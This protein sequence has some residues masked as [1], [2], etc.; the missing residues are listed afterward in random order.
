MKSVLLFALCRVNLGHLGGLQMILMILSVRFRTIGPQT[1]IIQNMMQVEL[2]LTQLESN[3]NHLHFRYEIRSG[4]N[5]YDKF[6]S[7]E[8]FLADFITP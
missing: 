6:F 2:G 4:G 1:P 5:I 3:Y 8:E 7:A